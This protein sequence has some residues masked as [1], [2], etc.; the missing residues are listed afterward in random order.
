MLSR[1][2]RTKGYFFAICLL[3]SVIVCIFS[4]QLFRQTPHQ[5]IREGD[6]LGTVDRLSKSDTLNIPLTSLENYLRIVHNKTQRTIMRNLAHQHQDAILAKDAHKTKTNTKLKEHIESVS[7][8]ESGSNSENKQG[9][10]LKNKLI[11]HLNK[12]SNTH[13]NTSNHNN[14]NNNNNNNSIDTK[15]VKSIDKSSNSSSVV[16]NKYKDNAN[17]KLQFLPKQSNNLGS[18]NNNYRNNNNDS[19]SLLVSAEKFRQSLNNLKSLKQ[20]LN[21]PSV[22]SKPSQQQNPNRLSGVFVEDI[23]NFHAP[24]ERKKALASRNNLEDALSRAAMDPPDHILTGKLC[25]DCLSSGFQYDL[26]VEDICHTDVRLVILVESPPSNQESRNAIR[27][28]WGAISQV[29]SSNVRVVFLLGKSNNPHENTLAEHEYWL[30]QDIVQ[31]D[32]VDAYA[33]LTYKTLSGLHWVNTFCSNA[34]YVMK[35]DDDMYVNTPL[36]TKMLLAS[37]KSR[38]LGGYCWGVSTPHRDSSSKWYVPYEMYPSATFPP[39]CSGTG[40]IMSQ[41]LVKNIINMSLVIGFFYLEDVYV[42]LCLEKFNI[43][44]VNIQGFSNMLVPFDSCLFRNYVLTSH[45]HTPYDLQTEWSQVLSCYPKDLTP[46]QLFMPIPYPE[47]D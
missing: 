15:H 33:N 11:H 25:Q 32:F 2:Q 24:V 27:K 4:W 22:S 44:P 14:T 43:Y 17:N 37:P 40:Y 16:G 19:S 47:V 36:I 9:S 31:I 6:R 21:S 45:G 38:F 46:H 34:K 23:H 1:L 12:Y 8:A 30:N 10:L 5:P 18:S 7:S 28:T 20:K 41:D 35:T 42:A 39:M 13:V 26:N 3:L 29:S